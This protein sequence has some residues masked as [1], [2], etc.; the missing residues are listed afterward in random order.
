MAN[1]VDEPYEVMSEPLSAEERYYLEWARETEKRN[2]TLI[3]EVLRQLVTL[4]VALLAGSVA[5]LKEGILPIGFRVALVMCLLASLVASLLGVIPF[6]GT[7]A[8]S[9]LSIKRHK[10]RAVRWKHFWLRLAAGL[11]VVGFLCAIL[12]LIG[13]IPFLAKK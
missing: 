5:F 12:G 3:N 4:T 2:L 7:V 9:P 1:G 10:E 11:L 6:Q 13:G 8:G